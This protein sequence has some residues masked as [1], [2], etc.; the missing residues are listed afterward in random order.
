[1]RL[2]LA[3]RDMS[4]HLEKTG[5]V[6]S[7]NPSRVKKY[8]FGSVCTKVRFLTFG[9]ITSCYYYLFSVFTAP[10]FLVFMRLTSEGGHRQN[11]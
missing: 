4:F 8:L 3:Y 10:D 11:L 2:S 7:I 6:S 9:L 1:M 5:Y